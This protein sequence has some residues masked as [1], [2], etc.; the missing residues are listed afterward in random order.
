MKDRDKLT[1]FVSIVDE[2]LKIEGNAWLIDELLLT[3]ENHATYAQLR[4]HP[5]ITRIHEYCVEEIIEKQ[6]EEF[7][8]EFPIEEIKEQL[9]VDFL[10]MEH[11]RR[12]DNFWK[13]SLCMFQQ[14]ESI[15]NYLFEINYRQWKNI[16]NHVLY[17]NTTIHRY[18]LNSINKD[19][20][21]I[22]NKYKLIEIIYFSGFGNDKEHKYFTDLFYYI[23][24]SRNEIHRG[25]DP[26]DDKNILIIQKN[27]SKYYFPFYGALYRFVNGIP[28]D[29]KT[30]WQDFLI[31]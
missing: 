22:A 4:K 30:K 3:I 26:N 21:S 2:I 12:R 6:A 14:F 17:G 18:M 10:E 11:E 1:Q 24:S 28:L 29:Y 20:W 23:K 13:Y 7:Y 5:L 19:G 9:I 16:K 27:P 15:T 8:R 25:S 31:K